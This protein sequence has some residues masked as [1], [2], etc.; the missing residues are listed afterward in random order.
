MESYLDYQGAKFVSR[1][2]ANTYLVLNKLMDLH[3]VGR[4]RGGIDAALGRIVAP[5]MVMSVRT[6][7]LYPRPQQ[8]RI[9]EA[10]RRRATMRVEHIDIDSDN[11]HDGFLTEPDQTGPPM[12]EFIDDIY[13]RRHGRCGSGVSRRREQVQVAG[14]RAPV[15][16]ERRGDRQRRLGAAG[17]C[18][19]KRA[20][21]GRRLGLGRVVAAGS[22]AGPAHRGVRRGLRAVPAANVAPTQEGRCEPAV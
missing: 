3:D 1:F 10:L 16:R 6:D 20:V 9:V 15:L 4:G 19:Y 11:G 8:L 5:T 7:F 17:R 13:K 21:G 18:A 2:D 12:G 14:V 22:G